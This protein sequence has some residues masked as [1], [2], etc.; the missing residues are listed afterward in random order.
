M[1][2]VNIIYIINGLFF[3][4][5]LAFFILTSFSF[6]ANSD[7]TEVKEYNCCS[8]TFDICFNNV[9]IDLPFD[10]GS[11]F[12]PHETWNS[13]LAG[14]I[15]AIY[16]IYLLLSGP[17]NARGPAGNSFGI[18]TAL[19][20]FVMGIVTIITTLTYSNN[21]QEKTCNAVGVAGGEC[22][23]TYYVVSGVVMAAAGVATGIQTR[24]F[25]KE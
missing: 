20:L 19:L 4:A 18:I 11:N 3:L 16:C 1:P 6:Q 21:A 12:C 24:L 5:T 7:S 23:N 17:C 22:S 13:V 10:L 9:Q 2:K 15:I 25:T 8:E 14:A